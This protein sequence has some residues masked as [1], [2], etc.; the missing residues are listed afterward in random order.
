MFSVRPR[1]WLHQRQWQVLA[2]LAFGAPLAAI[3]L[4]QYRW[5]QE[6]SNRSRQAESQQNR[7]TVLSAAAMLEDRMAGARLET[8]PP[9]VHEDVLEL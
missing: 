4:V 5:L 9:I 1:S 7:V 8:L 2:V 3:A 6:L